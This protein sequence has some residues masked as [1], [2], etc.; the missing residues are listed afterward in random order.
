MNAGST[1]LKTD[2]AWTFATRI[3]MV[4]NSVAAGIIVAHWLGA[5]GVGQLAVINVAVATLVQL[6]S[7]GLPSANT[8]FIA[9]DPDRLRTAAINSA[10]VALFWGGLLGIGLGLLAQFRPEWFGF[11]SGDLIRIAAVSIPSQLITLIGLNILLAV[12]KLRAFNLLDLAGQSFVLIN[13]LLALI[14][15]RRGLTALVILNTAAAIL[16]SLAVAVLIWIAARKLARANWRIDAS[17]LAQMIRYGIKFHISILAAAIIFRAD[18]LIVNHFRGSTE[19][20][21]YSVATQFGMLLMLLPGVIATLLFPRVTAKQD[22]QGETTALVTRYTA[23]VTFLS[24]LAA[25]PFS[26]LLPLIYGAEFREAS[27]LLLILLPGVY[28]VGLESVMVQH[29]N[30]LGLP[31]IIPFYWIVT[32]IINIVLVF[33]WVPRLGA[34]GAAVAS[35]LSYALIFSFVTREFLASTGQSFSNVFI[36]R[37][38]EL[39]QLLNLSTFVGATR[40]SLR[41]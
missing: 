23:F 6:G 29:F 12:G 21:V 17:L 41:G 27:G 35:T 10:I 40:G 14:V 25:V 33:L 9:Q 37:R 26:F 2:V 31:R 18:L 15:L 39:R 36:L 24:C 13:A 38:S 11:V 3:L 34:Q 1:R 20:G 19:A 22:Q 5:D 8:Y 16:V 30:A 4:V 28:L 7:L 32:L